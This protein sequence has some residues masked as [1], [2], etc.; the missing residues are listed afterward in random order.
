MT[1]SAKLFLP[2]A[3]R[4]DRHPTKHLVTLDVDLSV[5]LTIHHCNTCTTLGL[6]LSLYLLLDAL[7]VS[8][9]CFVTITTHLGLTA[10]VKS[11]PPS[12]RDIPHLSESHTFEA[13]LLLSYREQNS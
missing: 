2:E 12:P 4:H 11:L 5:L 13:P 9:L 3:S 7:E 10:A 8:Y 1:E 6:H